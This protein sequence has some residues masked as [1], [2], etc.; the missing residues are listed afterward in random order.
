MFLLGADSFGRDI[1]SRLLHGARISL[2]VALDVDG[3]RPAA[4]RPG[5]AWSG[6]RGGW[7]DEV[8]MR[9]ADFVLVLPIIYVVL[10]LRAVMPLVLPPSTVFC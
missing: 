3:G 10:I 7:L 9:A 5:W 8:L 6:Y 2:G 4:R 1:L